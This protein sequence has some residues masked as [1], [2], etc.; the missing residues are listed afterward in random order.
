MSLLEGLFW[1]TMNIYHEARSEEQ[2][3]QLAVAHVTI[4]RTRDRNQTFKQVV[5]APYQF[6]W[7]HLRASWQPDDMPALY[8]C[9]QSALI[10]LREHDFTQ[11][12]TYYHRDDIKPHWASHY[13]YVATFG[14]HVFYR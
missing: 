6:S 13:Q 12:A 2:F 8:Q 4:N 1:L 3:A 11:G 5:L 7:T 10:A 9:L 14:S